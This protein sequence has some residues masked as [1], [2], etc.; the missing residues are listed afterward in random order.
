MIKF[1]NEAHDIIY[2]LQGKTLRLGQIFVIVANELSQAGHDPFHA[3]DTLTTQTLNSLLARTTPPREDSEPVRED[4]NLEAH[5]K[6][7][8]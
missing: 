2:R 3:P 8:E 5:Q 1:N 6:G 7:E 4:S